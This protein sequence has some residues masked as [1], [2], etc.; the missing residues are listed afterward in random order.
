MWNYPPGNQTRLYTA[1]LTFTNPEYDSFQKF[2]E[3]LIQ[4]LWKVDWTCWSM[5][6][7]LPSGHDA[8]ISSGDWSGVGV[9]ADG[10]SW[11]FQTCTLLVEAIGFS[12]TRNSS[13]FPPRDWSLDWLTQHCRRRFGVTPMPYEVVRRWKFDDLAANNVTRILFTNGENDG[14]SVGGFPQN[15]SSSLLV[16]N[17]PN[18]A[19][20]SDLSGQGPTDA[21]SEDIK[22]GFRSIEMFLGSWLDEI[23]PLFS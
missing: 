11:D 18:G 2:R 15:L 10:E 23:R 9:G 13:M 5:N 3:F 20:H 17:F 19:H 22:E 7:Q 14:W 8:T 6:L 4:S 21:D 1:C 16:L 12:S